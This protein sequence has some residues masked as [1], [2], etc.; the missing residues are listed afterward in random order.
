[1]L[2][3]IWLPRK[4]NSNT[5]RSSFLCRLTN[6]PAGRPNKSMSSRILRVGN[7]PPGPASDPDPAAAV[8]LVRPSSSSDTDGGR[9]RLWAFPTDKVLPLVGLGLSAGLDC[10]FFKGFFPPPPPVFFLAPFLGAV[11][12]PP[13]PDGEDVLLVL[14]S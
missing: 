7:F 10:C 6:L 14:L 9:V 2:Y 1:M 5:A 12:P 4:K 3:N 11:K 13:P 8:A